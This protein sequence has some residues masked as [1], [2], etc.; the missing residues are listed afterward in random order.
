M[1]NFVLPFKMLLTNIH[2]FKKKKNFIFQKLKWKKSAREN[3][4]RYS[5]QL[6][7]WGKKNTKIRTSIS[8]KESTKIIITRV[9]EC[10]YSTRILRHH[11]RKA[12]PRLRCKNQLEMGPAHPPSVYYQVTVRPSRSSAQVQRANRFVKRVKAGSLIVDETFRKFL[13]STPQKKKCFTPLMR[14]GGEETRW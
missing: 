1:H 5:S 11:V 8:V 2:Y 4:N 10:W 12:R 14:R 9:Q 13:F 7:N 6:K 3:Q